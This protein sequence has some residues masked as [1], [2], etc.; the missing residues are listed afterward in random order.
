MTVKEEYVSRAKTWEPLS[1]ARDYSW[2]LWP[3]VPLYPY[4]Q[5][6]TLVRE[7]VN[8]TIWTFE[9]VQGIFY[10]IVPIRMTVIK[11]EAGGLL[12]YAPVAPTPECIRHMKELEAQHGGVKYII[13]PTAVGIEHKVFAGPFARRFQTAQVF[14][15]PHQWSFPLNLPLSWLGFPGHRTQALPLNSAEAPFAD[16]FDYDILG[17]LKLGPGPF[18]EVAF[19][20]HRSRTLLVTDAI[21]SVPAEPPAVLQLD[22]YPMLYHAKD[23]A[24]EVVEDNSAT[25][26]KGWQR[27]SLFALYFR[28]ST[29]D[30]IGWGQA[31]REARQAPD[32][33]KR[34]YFGLF[35]VQWNP[36]WQ[37]SFEALHG[38]GRLLVA[39]I[40][41]TLVLNRGPQAVI[42]WADRVVR[43]N[44]Q[45]IIPCHFDAPLKA[46]PSQFRE[47]FTFLEKQP[48]WGRDPGDQGEDNQPWSPEDVKFLNFLNQ[49]L[50]RRQIAPP[51]QEKV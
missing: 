32:R 14:V 18:E 51:P 22:P 45:R 4:G 20:H 17:P 7:V 19:H 16:E 47:A 3:V 39:P 34:A 38:G 15:C 9:Q 28:P 21:V 12:V 1:R 30:V 36:E 27:I 35:P 6:P 42:D 48:S 31:W 50:S 40:L 25:R 37:Q 13:V 23:N 49:E 2:P 43:W 5:R 33:S 41:Q 24:L 11:L 26:R 29:L 8:G 10:V 44:F 46:H